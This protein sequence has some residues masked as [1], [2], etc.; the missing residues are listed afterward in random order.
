[1]TMNA[2]IS[3]MAI[4]SAVAVAAVAA[5]VA[6][7]SWPVGEWQAEQLANWL[8]LLD[9]LCLAFL[10]PVASSYIIIEITY[11]ARP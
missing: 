2:I 7:A 3:F 5:A 10:R 9:C 8:S 4:D 11:C 6:I 1:M